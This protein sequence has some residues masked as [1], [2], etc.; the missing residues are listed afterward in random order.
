LS[1]LIQSLPSRPF[2][3]KRNIF[4]LLIGSYFV[5]QAS[6]LLSK[7]DLL[8]ETLVEESGEH[9]IAGAGELHLETSLKFL[10]NYTQIPMNAFHPFVSYRYLLLIF[11]SQKSGTCTQTFLSSTVLFLVLRSFLLFNFLWVQLWICSA[12]ELQIRIRSRVK[13]WIQAVGR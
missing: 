8:V 4:R 2:C 1:R 11:S 5:F 10:E 7:S 9:V 6:K 13:R 3:L 12:T